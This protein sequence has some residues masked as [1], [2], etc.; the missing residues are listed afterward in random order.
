MIGICRISRAKKICRDK[1]APVSMQLVCS[2]MITQ[3]A[4]PGQLQLTLFGNKID[5]DDATI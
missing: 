2:D 5:E 3:L 4:L 1:V